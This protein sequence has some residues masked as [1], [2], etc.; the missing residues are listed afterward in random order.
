MA[1]LLAAVG[2]YGIVTQVVI[3]R[4]LMAISAGS[5]ISAGIGLG[6][7]IAGEA[8]GA[9]LAGRVP[10]TRIGN[11]LLWLA[12]V[13]TIAAPVGV[14]AVILGPSL[15]GALPG[16]GTDIPRVF[17]ITLVSGFI[18]ALTHG[19]LFV[20]GLAAL[21]ASSGNRGNAGPGYVWEGLGTALAAALTWLLL[22]PRV[23][24]L[25]LV[26]LFGIPVLLLAGIE[27]ALRSPVRRRV[28][29]LLASAGVVVLLL[30][31][32]WCSTDLTKYAWKRSWRGQNVTAV[33]NSSYGK[34]VR[35]ERESQ[36]LLVYDGSTVLSE[37]ESDPA[38]AEQLAVVPMLV[39]PRPEHAL[40]VG[41]GFRLIKVLANS[42]LESVT[43]VQID[44]VLHR[45][46]VSTIVPPAT[47]VLHRPKVTII[48]DDPRGFLISSVR[49]FDCI[50]IWGEAPANL[51]A[52]R[53]FT[54]EFF[55]LCRTGLVG[56]GIL[57]VS[58]PG[59]PGQINPESQMTLDIRAAA[60]GAVFRH[61]RLMMLDFPLL[62][63]SVGTLDV[64]VDTLELRLRGWNWRPTVLRHD[65]LTDL[66][67]VPRQRL[68]SRVLLSPRKHPAVGASTDQRP[69][70][71]FLGLLR[72]SRLHSPW[73]AD[74]YRSAAS[75]NPVLLLVA[76]T[77][78]LI[79]VTLGSI[80]RRH[81]FADPV[82]IFSSGF[83]G[84]AISTVVLFA[85]QV[86]FGSA[87]AEV[88]LLLAAFMVGTALGGWASSA[89]AGGRANRAAFFTSA[90]IL[91]V[92][93][94]GILAVIAREGPGFLFLAV[95]LGAGAAVGT[96]FPIAAA[97]LSA[98]PLGSR[99][100]RVAALDLA[101]GFLGAT[102]CAVFVLPVWGTAA[103]LLL[104][105]Y[106]KLTSL[107]GQCLAVAGT[108]DAHAHSV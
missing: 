4:E 8:V 18:P 73:F 19:A 60:L 86:R 2:G 6:V 13:S 96:Q 108:G 103:A 95:Q 43:L 35:L 29:R 39:H 67:A 11:L 50:I 15:L 21:G 74:I 93:A 94:S 87:F 68:L 32:G 31:L 64:Q 47:E 65:Y 84:A 72:E 56:E 100:G 71:V 97:R 28:R 40:I 70:E 22:L 10:D 55:A 27:S 30:V 107:V 16:E 26:A 80:G 106:L 17:A 44:P 75:L 78:L 33:E 14:L 38:F 92:L 20:S 61:V 105:L 63:A 81:R 1:L 41:P 58:G 51:A 53:L 59:L 77:V 9:L 48:C 82:S 104:V 79:V 25:A 102:I 83:A 76:A 99:A 3:L 54:R 36:K 101:G 52:N 62:L 42:P 69:S 45:E 89:A 49:R 57:A 66:L 85:Y 24:S 34:V 12:A 91:L 98:A 46:A 37:P 7:W 88:G 23:N 90:E 5:E